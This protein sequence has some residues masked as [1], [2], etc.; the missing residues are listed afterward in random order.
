MPRWW[1]RSTLEARAVKCLGDVLFKGAY[2]IIVRPGYVGA[3]GYLNGRPVALIVRTR[4]VLESIREFKRVYGL[5][6]GSI[7]IIR[8]RSVKAALFIRRLIEHGYRV[9]SIITTDSEVRRMA[10]CSGRIVERI[11]SSIVKALGA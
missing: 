9:H 5:R 7:V 3:I 2:D 6:S 10:R 8:A 4:G 11:A 1:R